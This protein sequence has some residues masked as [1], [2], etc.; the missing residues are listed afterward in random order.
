MKITFLGTG[1]GRFTTISQKRMSGGFRIDNIHGF[2]LH[3]DPGPGALI[4][5]LEY[6]LNPGHINGV[7]ISHCH[8]DHYNDAE[9][10]IEAMTKGM[11]KNYGNIIGSKSVMEGAERWG[12]S[13]SNYHK[14]NSQ[15]YTLTPDE[16]IDFDQFKIKG[17][18][19]IHGDPYGVG[20]QIEN[21]GFKISYTADTEYFDE[22]A[23]Y[24]KNADILIGSVLR[25]GAK[26]I[27]GHMCT[28]NF[29]DLVEKVQ[30]SLAIM[31][32][33]G[34]K[35]IAANPVEEAIRVSKK[36]GVRTL[37]AFDGMRVDVNERNPERSKMIRLK[38]RFAARMKQ[39]D[40]F[41]VNFKSKPKKKNNYNKDTNKNNNYNNEDSNKNNNYNSKKNNNSD[42]NNNDNF[43]TFN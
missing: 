24:H 34:F 32:H 23:K 7:F 41:A 15:N 26:S 22:L 3:V 33:F 35:M 2:N 9:V 36:T 14:S 11:T 8:T 43:T 39:E 10:L 4:R 6:R 42:G 40:V 31:T 19:T 38:D 5:S 16:T 30:P 27:R 1:G 12:P 37:A 25:P 21:N 18:K 29:I 28:N 17:T 13:I 20:F